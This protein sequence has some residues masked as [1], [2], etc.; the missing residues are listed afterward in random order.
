MT[1]AQTTY[2]VMAGNFGRERVLASGLSRT[3]AEQI[4][5]ELRWS[6]IT[7]GTF[8]FLERETTAPQTPVAEP[9]ETNAAVRKP[10]EFDQDA[11]VAR[12]L[13]HVAAD[14]GF[15][16][17]DGALICEG[18]NG[19]YLVDPAA[20]TCTCGDFEHRASKVGGT[21]KHI[22]AARHKLLAEGVLPEPTRPTA[23]KRNVGLGERDAAAVA[24]F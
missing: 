2:R 9:V 14:Y 1:T 8:T 15:T 12:A 24:T 3:E 4:R 10:A 22:V 23:P 7:R 20:G 5:E 21:C 13:R 19:A 11:R 6:P 16:E 18:P 17:Y